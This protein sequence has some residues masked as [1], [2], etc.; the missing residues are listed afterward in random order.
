MIIV[1]PKSVSYIFWCPFYKQ[2][3]IFI[4]SA[5]HSTLNLHFKR[6]VYTHFEYCTCSSKM[7]QYFD[8][9]I[10]CMFRKPYIVAFFIISVTLKVNSRES[11][12]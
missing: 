12:G 1:L 7:W 2:P 3:S 10:L 11:Q 9:V 8:T 4:I 5:W 6:L